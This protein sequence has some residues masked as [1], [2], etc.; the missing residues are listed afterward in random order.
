MP[1][2]L[3]MPSAHDEPPHDPVLLA[4]WYAHRLVPEFLGPP[5][6]WPPAYQLRFPLDTAG[7][8]KLTAFFYINGIHPDGIAAIANHPTM[9]TCKA[10]R[11]GWLTN[12]RRLMHNDDYRARVYA[13][14]IV[15]KC[16]MFANGERRGPCYPRFYLNS[17]VFHVTAG[18]ARPLGTLGIKFWDLEDE[19]NLWKTISKK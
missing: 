14:D 4:V 9:F 10:G 18:T 16:D 13:Y 7:R 8:N 5:Q 3:E 6:T 2:A 15:L 17:F 1:A 11:E 19:K 12:L